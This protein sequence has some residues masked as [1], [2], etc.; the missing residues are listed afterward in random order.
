[1]FNIFVIVIVGSEAMLE[2]P[3]GG[4]GPTAREV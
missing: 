2:P 3:A 1:M 4:P